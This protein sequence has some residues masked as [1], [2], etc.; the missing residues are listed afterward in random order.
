MAAPKQFPRFI[1]TR[2]REA[3]DDTPVVL[4]HGPR[5]CGKT[6][7]AQKV[8]EELDHEYLTFDDPTTVEAALA[9]PAAFANSLPKHAI[10]DEVQRVPELFSALKLNIDRHREPGRLILTGSAN[11]LLMPQLSDSLAGRME[12]IRLHPLSRCEIAG[13]DSN[14]IERLF[15]GDHLTSAAPPLGDSLA[16]L[17][18]VGGFPP[19]I[20]RSSSRRAAW[21]SNFMDGLVQRE[22]LNLAKIRSLDDLSKLL[23]IACASTSSLLNVSNLA[24]DFDFSRTTINDYLTLLEQVFMVDLLPAWHSKRLTRLVKSPKL[25]VSDTGL[26]CGLQ[27]MG[28]DALLADR[29]YFGRV[30]ETF[31]LEE[32]RRMASWNRRSVT[33]HHFREKGGAE[34]DLVLER[35]GREVAGVE[36]KLAQTVK[37]DDFRGLRRL[38]EA[39]GDA[40][41]CGVVIYDGERAAPFG[42]KLLAVP[43]RSLWEAQ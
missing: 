29:E 36:V 30:V 21:Y 2:L 42:E 1:E 31:V 20:A 4:I 23:Q 3:L 25:H 7:L 17:V 27:D 15:S 35:S 22:V 39:S 8:G 16:S 18:T 11:L 6:T 37:S 24:Q 43:I 28:A 38:A 9:D 34:V 10:L 14:F 12:T 19:A 13:R 41:K 40:F 32:V 5:Q 26:V 33:L